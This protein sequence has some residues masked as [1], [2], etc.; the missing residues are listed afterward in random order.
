MSIFSTV[1]SQALEAVSNSS[2][3]E[4]NKMHFIGQ[5]LSAISVGGIVTI[6]QS[7]CRFLA[8]TKSGQ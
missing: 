8:H 6:I 2:M 1:K 3:T 4:D 5:I 7:V